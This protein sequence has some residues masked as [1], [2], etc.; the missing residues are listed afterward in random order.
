MSCNKVLILCDVIKGR[1]ITMRYDVR[2]GQLNQIHEMID[3]LQKFSCP[4]RVLLSK[5][6]LIIKH[7]TCLNNITG[8]PSII[9][10]YNK[11]DVDMST[12]EL[13]DNVH[14]FTDHDEALEL[15]V[16]RLLKDPVIGNEAKL[17]QALILV[18]EICKHARYHHRQ[19]QR[20]FNEYRNQCDGWNAVLTNYKNSIE[21]SHRKYDSL[22]EKFDALNDTRAR[23]FTVLRKAQ[24]SM[25]QLKKISFFTSSSPSENLT[26]K[27]EGRLFHVRHGQENRRIMI[28][29]HN[30]VK[31]V[32]RFNASKDKLRKHSFLA[33]LRSDYNLDNISLVTRYWIDVLDALAKEEKL[34]LRRRLEEYVSTLL[35]NSTF[36]Y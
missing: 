20:M 4:E 1:S 24:I 18:E 27:E 8:Q 28:N 31:C 25:N 2:R 30:R 17:D 12:E 13:L 22:L 33:Y 6:G 16:A 35:Q 3:K 29:Q 15:L 11:I 9:F 5:D 34:A 26:A 14:K 36:R 7:E 23:D 21:K 19:N 32:S 10:F